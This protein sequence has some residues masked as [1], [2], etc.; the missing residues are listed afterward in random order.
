MLKFSINAQDGKTS[1]RTAI[2]SLPHGDVPTPQFM[3]VGTNGTVK[4]ITHALLE[5][6]G[7]GLILGNTYH[8]YLRPG[9]EVI[10][11]AGGLHRFSS[12]T[13][14]ILT[15][16]GGY[17]I[18]SLAPFRKIKEDG[19]SF[20]SHIDGSSHFLTPE[21]VID[22]QQ[23]LGSD[24]MMTLDVCTP[25]G[26]DYRSAI[27]A[28]EITSQWARRSVERSR[29]RYADSRGNLFGIVQGNFFED[30]RARSAAEIT[31]LDLPG[32]A[33]GGLS[34][35]E[36]FRQ[37][38]DMLAFTAPL[39][40]H[41]KPRYL[42]GVGTPEYIFA[43]VENGIDLF[44][45]VFPTRIARNG[46][47]FTHNGVLNLKREDNRLSLRPLDEKCD[48]PVC[49]TYTRAYI[50]HLF[51][52]KE[53]LAAMLATHHNLYFMA[54]LLD[55][56]RQSIAEHR[57]LELKSSFLQAYKENGGAHGKG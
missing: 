34:V 27:E 22:I 23:I 9:L 37:F 32:F 11:A 30:L 10:Q 18:F 31:E 7:I 13:H 29:D 51:K 24:I 35:G 3:P 39:L 28:L 42:M 52:A 5:E 15:D 8:L 4:A 17:Q 19:V 20:R 1:A 54:R 44:D 38:A 48:C 57:F 46:S 53:I 41:D 14:N 12:W 45:C 43:A 21:A 50:R 25:P 49:K 6:T 36:S 56:I 47:V 2:L 55:Q 26:I 40:P 33:I 16:S